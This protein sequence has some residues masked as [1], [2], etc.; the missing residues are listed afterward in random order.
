MAPPDKYTSDM[1]DRA[2]ELLHQGASKA[3]IASELG[4]CRAT[5]HNWLNPEHANYR[6]EFKQAID[7]GLVHA[8]AFWEK[9][10]RKAALGINKDANATLMIFTMKNRFK[11]DWS[12]S[13]TVNSN[14]NFAQ[15]SETPLTPD[16]W[17]KTHK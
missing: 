2:V 17:L 6:A 14:V 12:D 5:V 3:E 16:E 9:E 10:L 7:E 11:E 4:V 13:H 8:Q 15:V 1:C